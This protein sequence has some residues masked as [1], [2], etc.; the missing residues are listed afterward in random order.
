MLPSANARLPDP[1]IDW[2]ADRPHLNGYLTPPPRTSITVDVAAQC[3][4]LFRWDTPAR[5]YAISTSKYGLGNTQDSQQTPLGL[6]SIEQKIGLGCQSGEV[7]I[8]R[9][10]QGAHSDD[11]LR[12]KE[13]IISSR[14]LWLRGLEPGFNAGQLC[15]SHKRY[16][17][18]HG[19]P[20][21][22]SLGQPASIGCIRMA[23]ADIIDLFD[24]T[25]IHA[26]VLIHP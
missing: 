25:P 14:I 18:I 19:T 15:D 10:P 23:D 24:R 4:S 1:L 2:V 20:H 9:V 16:I 8:G 26:L 21:A 12:I 13:D 3:L 6:H 11:Y 5:T 7:F 22:Q 17:Y